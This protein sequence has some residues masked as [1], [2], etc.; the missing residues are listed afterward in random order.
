[1]KK[2][3]KSKPIGKNNPSIEDVA[4]IAGVSTAT[5]SRVINNFGSV[6]E[7]NRIKVLETVNKLKYRPNISASRLAS[8]SSVNSI[9]LVMPLYDDMFGS[10]FFI[11]LMKGIRSVLLKKRRDLILLYDNLY[12]NSDNFFTRVLNKTYIGGLIMQL[13]EIKINPT[14]K[15]S[16]VPYVVMDSYFADPRVNCIYVKNKEGAYG[17]VGHLIEL[18]HRRIA[19]IHGPTYLQSGIDRLQ[20]YRQALRD[21][22]LAMDEALILNGTFNKNVAYEKMKELLNLKNPP[23]AVFTASDEMALGAIKAIK[24]KGLGIPKDISIIG[25]DDN[26]L[27]VEISPQLTTVRQ[28][29]SEMGRLCA[30]TIISL[31]DGHEKS[32]AKNILETKLIIRDSCRKLK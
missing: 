5:V 32:C 28:P 27:C 7:S 12:E 21:N 19:T 22:G 11:E 10:N 2:P 23:T 3:L 14:L 17:A 9:G 20:G 13:G 18:G 29:I 24:E 30:E 25:F 16:E 6:K 1:M 4:K 15:K 26:P 8:S 31:V